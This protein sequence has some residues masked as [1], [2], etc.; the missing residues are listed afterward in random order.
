MFQLNLDRALSRMRGG[1]AGLGLGTGVAVAAGKPS[2]RGQMPVTITDY[3]KVKEEDRDGKETVVRTERFER[4]LTGEELEQAKELIKVVR[5]NTSQNQQIIDYN[6]Q[7]AAIKNYLDLAQKDLRKLNPQLM[8]VIDANKAIKELVVA[9]N[10]KAVDVMS[11]YS[12]FGFDPANG[13][14]AVTMNDFKLFTRKRGYTF[15]CKDQTRYTILLDTVLTGIRAGKV[16]KDGYGFRNVIEAAK[17]VGE[18]NDDIKTYT[19]RLTKAQA[20]H[21]ELTKNLQP[22][23]SNNVSPDSFVDSFRQALE[24]TRSEANKIRSRIEQTQQS[25]VALRAVGD[26]SSEHSQMLVDGVTAQIRGLE[27]QRTNVVNR[28]KEI[29]K[30]IARLVKEKA[31]VQLKTEKSLAVKREQKLRQ[32]EDKY[33]G[34]RNAK[35]LIDAD[36]FEFDRLQKM[37]LKNRM[38]AVENKHAGVPEDGNNKAAVAILKAQQGEVI[39]LENEMR[40]LTENIGLLRENLKNAKLGAALSPLARKERISLLQQQL[41]IDR[42]S[43]KTVEKRKDR[44]EQALV[45]QLDPDVWEARLN[46]FLAVEKNA[47]QALATMPN[48]FMYNTLLSGASDRAKEQSRQRWNAFKKFRTKEVRLPSNTFMDAHF[49]AA[50]FVPVPKFRKFTNEL[51][52][53]IAYGLGAAFKDQDIADASA[54]LLPCLLG[55]VAPT[56]DSE[57]QLKVEFNK[58][59]KILETWLASPKALPIAEEIVEE[60][61]ATKKMP[62]PVPGKAPSARVIKELANQLLHMLVTEKAVSKLSGVAFQAYR[63]YALTWLRV[64]LKINVKV[65]RMGSGNIALNPA[66]RSAKLTPAPVGKAPKRAPISAPKASLPSPVPTT[67]KTTKTLKPGTIK[68]TAPKKTTKTVTPTK[69]AVKAPAKPKQAPMVNKKKPT[70]GKPVSNRSRFA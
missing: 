55:V 60:L 15:I 50:G 19:E 27:K 62:L 5:T 8:R 53:I 46:E 29:G 42:A 31:Q 1:V 17:A 69:P 23:R 65:G 9:K 22:G 36:M 45:T 14:D 28:L 44:R 64:A 26:K 16:L 37:A 52:Q 67:K 20:K 39:D 68:I 10:K 11:V 66:A 25:L 51:N 40:N 3:R 48:V 7:I 18:L 33:Y 38:A 59:I 13:A 6:D 32:L 61:I 43:L 70:L 63:N 30:G 47:K 41:E 49:G 4:P 34:K 12:A 21:A 54:I 35:A 57:A 2:T 24:M 56:P 58:Q